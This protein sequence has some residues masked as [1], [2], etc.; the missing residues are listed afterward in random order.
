MRGLSLICLSLLLSLSSAS[1]VLA[2]SEKIKCGDLDILFWELMHKHDFCEL[3]KLPKKPQCGEGRK[4]CGI[5]GSHC[6]DGVCSTAC[7]IGKPE[8]PDGFHCDSGECED[9]EDEQEKPP[10]LKG[11]I[12]KHSGPASTTCSEESCRAGSG[13]QNCADGKTKCSEYSPCVGDKCKEVE[14]HQSRIAAEGP[15][16]DNSGRYRN[17]T[18]LPSM[19]APKKSTNGTSVV[20]VKGTGKHTNGTAKPVRKRPS[21]RTKAHPPVVAVSHQHILPKESALEVSTEGYG[22]CNV[23]RRLDVVC[24]PANET[25]VRYPR[26]ECVSEKTGCSK[27]ADEPGICI[28][29]VPSHNH[30]VCLNVL[31]PQLVHATAF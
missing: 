15:C 31:T 3:K 22:L 10:V 13:P 7:G 21:P 4:R 23:F 18:S 28:G 6:D 5:P 17:Q 9:L 20:S 1:V 27:L 30:Q 8:C 16:I 24:K 19:M 12:E 29:C 14:C 26:E 25:C 11:G 2:E